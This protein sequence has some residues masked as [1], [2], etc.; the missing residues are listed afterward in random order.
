MPAKRTLVIAGARGLAAL[1]ALAVGAGAVAAAA[2]VPWPTYVAEPASLVV[3]P[4]ESAQLR[5]CPG[6][7]LALADD[8]SAATTASSFGAADLVTTVSPPTAAVERV[9]LEAPGNPDAAS[10]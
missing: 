10:V 8:A 4:S 5:V 9:D 3:E 2:L 1:A 6:P 7:L